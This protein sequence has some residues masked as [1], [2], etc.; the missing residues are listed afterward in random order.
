MWGIY[1]LDEQHIISFH[2]GKIL[3]GED[4]TVTLVIHKAYPLS[5]LNRVLD[6]W[7]DHQRVPWD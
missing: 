7:R 2:D 1:D 6:I 4:K 5:D 3:S